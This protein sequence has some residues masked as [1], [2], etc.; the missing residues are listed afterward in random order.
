LGPISYQWRFN[1]EVLP[2]AT[3]LT[4][5]LF[6]LDCDRSGV[7]QLVASNALEIVTSRLVYVAASND[8]CGLAFNTTM[9][10]PSPECLLLNSQFGDAYPLNIMLAAPSLECL[11]ITSRNLVQPP[12]NTT[13]AMP[14]I[15]VAV[16]NLSLLLPNPVENAFIETTAPPNP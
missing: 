13:I 16:T 2:G 3:N 14:L 1:G 15:T 7:Y 11:L 9:A 12:L 4:L 6:N 5:I 10:D 8:S